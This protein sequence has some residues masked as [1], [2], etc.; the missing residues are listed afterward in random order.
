M[1]S[2]TFSQMIRFFVLLFCVSSC[3]SL[4]AQSQWN[5]PEDKQMAQSQYARYTDAL[6]AKDYA[7][8]VEPLEWLL[9]HAPRLNKSIY[10]NGEIIYTQLAIRSTDSVAQLGHQSRIFE[11]LGLRE[12]YYAEKEIVSKRTAR[13]AYKF[14]KNVPEK[15]P[16]VV[17]SLRIS[18]DLNQEKVSAVTL[19]ALLDALR[20]YNKAANR[21]TEEE[22]ID[23][24]NM[25][26]DLMEKKKESVVDDAQ[27]K[28][29]L[30][31]MSQKID[32]LLLLCVQVDCDFVREV[33]G[34]RMLLVAE[35]MDSISQLLSDSTR[36]SFR[37]LLR[38]ARAVLRFMKKYECEDPAL[39]LQAVEILYAFD[40]SSRMALF[41]ARKFL[42]EG[43]QSTAIKYYTEGLSLSKDHQQRADIYMDMARLYAES[44]KSLS[45]G[46][47]RKA[48]GGGDLRDA[49]NLIGTLYVSSYELC[50]K[51][52]SRVED[53]AV[54]IAA[55]Q[56]F[57]RA[58]NEDMMQKTRAQFPTAEQMFELGLSEGTEIEIGCW[59]QEKVTLMKASNP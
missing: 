49:Y 2:Y 42:K 21:V 41:L 35:S 57:K 45:R 52:L 53:R 38:P 50:K 15:L 9:K 23:T 31:E 8:A 10:Q 40:P 1:I 12:K 54:F 59:I 36:N 30:D 13:L 44:D 25:L 3:A 58:G 29:R 14:Y 51:G 11:L 27:A 19:V 33:L 22:F 20:R 26:S 16:F 39:Y 24:Y 56:M 6:H 37:L 46:Y 7:A 47:A 4:C 32:K 55:Y 5:W 28:Q 18:I 43:E 34:A 17:S 48:L